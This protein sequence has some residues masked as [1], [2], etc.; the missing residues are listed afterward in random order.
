MPIAEFTPVRVAVSAS[1]VGQ[2]AVSALGGLTSVNA[3]PPCDNH[4]RSGGLVV[5]GRAGRLPA[6][7]RGERHQLCPLCVLARLQGT[8]RAPPRA[9]T[10]S[11]GEDRQSEGQG[12]GGCVLTV[13]QGGGAELGRGVLGC[14]PF[15]VSFCDALS[16]LHL[17]FAE[18][19]SCWEASDFSSQLV[20][21]EV[22]A[23]R[24]LARLE[25][26]G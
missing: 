13:A 2:T 7:I 18:K 10:P 12:G 20:G 17:D 22:C 6:D 14:D 9:G 8:E 19:L 5:G 11:E 15:L 25:Q 3:C 4:S 1:R 23:A 24:V 16:S 26:C 21:H